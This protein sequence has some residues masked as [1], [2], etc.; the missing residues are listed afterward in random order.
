VAK[1]LGKKPNQVRYKAWQLGVGPRPKVRSGRSRSGRREDLDQFFRSAWEA[2]IARYL[3]HLRVE[4]TIVSWEYEPETF[5]F[6]IKR[7]NRHYTPD[8]RVW[9]NETYYEWWEVKGWMDQASQTKIK[10][11]RK[12]YPNEPL[13]LIDATRYREIEREYASQ[14]DHWER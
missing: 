12:Y 2:N 4:Q 10:R 5:W 7:G 8:F 3:N 14:D 9:F 13:V 6:P 1:E 11:F